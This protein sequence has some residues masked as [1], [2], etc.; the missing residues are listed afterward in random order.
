MLQLS[1][2]VDAHDIPSNWVFEYYL[3]LHES[4]RGQTVVINSIFNTEKTP[5]LNIYLSTNKYKFKDFSSGYQGS[6]IDLV[7]YKYNLSFFEASHKIANDYRNYLQMSNHPHTLNMNL[8]AKVCK[9]SK[10]TT[11]LWNRED[12][13]YWLSYKIDSKTLEKYNVKPLSDYIY[14][15]VVG[16]VTE[17]YLYDSSIF[18]GYFNNAGELYKIYRPRFVD[19]KFINVKS[20]IQG[21]DQL[22][23]SKP[24]LIIQS[25][26]KDIMSYESLGISNTECIAGNS[27][28]SIID[29][30]DYLKTKYANICTLFDNDQAGKRAIQSYFDR[31]EIPGT[32]INL[33]K[34]ISDSIKV[35][36][37]EV[38]RSHV[39]K[40]LR[41]TLKINTKCQEP[42][43][44]EST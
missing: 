29:N 13:A 8:K 40:Q 19:V 20:Y 5:S 39:I 41:E 27:E 25:S 28:N 16:D 43:I 11:R 9:V 36:G 2:V 14:T 18:Y 4:L 38:V 30:L 10:Y 33:E 44:L 3:D 35:H 23:F 31:I 21:Y 17:H 42:S 12:A 37:I 22:T 26:L 1:Q 32:F 7:M 15:T 6:H 24:Y 34:D